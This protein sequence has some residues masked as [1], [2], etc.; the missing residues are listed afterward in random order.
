ML[1]VVSISSLGGACPHQIEGLTADGREVYSRYR[2]GRLS[3]R[4]AC[5]PGGSVLDDGEVVFSKTLDTTGWDGCLN[6]ATVAALTKGLI[7]WPAEV[8]TNGEPLFT[9]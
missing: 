4:V 3:I 9:P 7:E 2:W 1:T 8:T 6:G 5:K